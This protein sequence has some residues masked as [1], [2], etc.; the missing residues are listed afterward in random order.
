MFKLSRNALSFLV[1]LDPFG[2]IPPLGGPTP[3]GVASPAKL[4]GRK[5][6]IRLS[7]VAHYYDALQELCAKGIVRSGRYGYCLTPEGE[8]FFE[9]LRLKKGT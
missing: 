9:R 7:T 8:T 2:D 1:S 4:P 3:D 6:K 5:S